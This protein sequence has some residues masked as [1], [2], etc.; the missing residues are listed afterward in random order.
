[1]IAESERGQPCPHDR[2]GAKKRRAS[3]PR[4]AGFVKMSQHQHVSFRMNSMRQGF[5]VAVALLFIAEER[6]IAEDVKVNGAAELRDAVAAAKPGARL[7][8][9]GGNYGA[10][11]HFTNVRGEEKQPIIIMAAEAQ[12]PPVFRDGSA[13]MHFS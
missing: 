1:M 5:G 2:T 12:N 11:F 10:G 8:L 13:A 7:L 4:S 6:G 9:A 3:C